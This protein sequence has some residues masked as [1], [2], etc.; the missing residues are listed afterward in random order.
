MRYELYDLWTDGCTARDRIANMG[1]VF[2]CDM[3]CV[4]VCVCGEG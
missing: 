1:L 4:C 2:E 3:L